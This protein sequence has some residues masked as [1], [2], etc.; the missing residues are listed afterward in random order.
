MSCDLTAYGPGSRISYSANIAA[1]H[2]TF[3][4]EVLCT[5]TMSC[6]LVS[7][8][9]FRF[10]A[11]SLRLMST[12]TNIL[13]S[14]PD[15]SVALITLNRPKALNALSTPLFAE[16]N[17][18]LEEADAEESVG[19]IVLTGSDKAFAGTFFHRFLYDVR[20]MRHRFTAGAD[21]KEMKD[22]ECMLSKILFYILS[23]LIPAKLLMYIKTN[24][25]RAGV[26]YQNSG[27]QSLL[28][29]VDLR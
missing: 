27:S 25:S 3:T 20:S 2:V 23:S 11:S 17:Q 8:I 26:L 15:P 22:K 16:L 4:S 29:S 5:N 21:I 7:R 12:F 28:P 10:A 1:T 19:A 18:A 24:S 14:R 13:T 6:L 9:R